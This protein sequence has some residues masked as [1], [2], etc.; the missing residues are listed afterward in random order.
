MPQPAQTEQLPTADPALARVI[1]R[2]ESGG[3]AHALRFEP[4]IFRSPRA[5]SSATQKKIQDAHA[6]SA[7]TARVI[8]SC[9]W[10]LYQIMG[11]NLWD[12]DEPLTACT[13]FFDY[14]A[15]SAAQG[16]AFAA[17]LRAHDIMFTLDDLLDHRATLALFARVYNGDAVAYGDAIVS[18]AHA[19]GY[20]P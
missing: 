6:C 11:C 5:I 2:I 17:F 13:N 1:A 9:S 3:D 12:A 7:M 19:M 8:Y 14:C 15:D 16:D 20:V 18:A 4:L 10:G